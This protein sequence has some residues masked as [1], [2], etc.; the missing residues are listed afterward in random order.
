[1][2]EHISDASEQRLNELGYTQELKRSMSTFDVVAFG[3]IYMVP[4]APATLFGIVYNFSDGMPVLVFVI[5]AIAMIFSAMS[6]AEM[7]KR[8][9]IAGSV[10]SYVRRGL[11][12]GMGFMAGWAILLDYLLLPS[13]LAVMAA[14]AMAN[15]MPAVPAAVWVV[16]FVVA[17]SGVVLRGIKL[18][19]RANV[20]FLVIQLVVIAVFIGG[21]LIAIAQGRAKFQLGVLFTAEHFS[22]AIAFGAIPLAALCFIGFDAINT[23]N[24]EA[25]GGG[26]AVSKATMIV[27]WAV[28]AL[29]IAQVYFAALF[30][31]ADGFPTEDAVNNAFYDISGVVIAPWFKTVMTLAAALVAV[32]A[33]SI[34]SQA[35]TSRLVFSMARDHQ[36]PSFLAHISPN[37]R[38]PSYAVLLI[39]GISL[40][41]GLLGTNN[42]ALLSTMV[43]FGALSAYTML[44]VSVFIH[45]G[46]RNPSRN[47]WV[48]LVSPA[49]GAAVLVYSLWNADV[50]AKILGGSWLLVGAVI[51]WVLRARGNA[52]FT[53][54]DRDD[55]RS[56]QPA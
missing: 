26:K 18:T 49:I 55:E 13:M 52:S 21:A 20:I 5:A 22:W 4:L 48:H 56:A 29:F 53:A 30:V 12:T 23:L 31:P 6:Y 43:A 39:A 25:K 1:V 7:A 47:A 33:N 28:T 11:G 38:V 14:V 32:F 24:E 45:L 9:P 3:L 15:L 36:L 19:A 40:V 50:H 35:T 51:Y 27:L 34:A 41:I 46:V 8:Y 10:Y 17:A 44:H 2:N 37:R 42:L 54:S 16:A